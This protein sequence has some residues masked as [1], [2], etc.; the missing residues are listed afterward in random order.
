MCYFD[1]FENNVPFK[2][3]FINC[4]FNDLVNIDKII[5][6]IKGEW[7]NEME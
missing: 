6:R 7:E 1:Q 4:Y 2:S 5:I 3:S